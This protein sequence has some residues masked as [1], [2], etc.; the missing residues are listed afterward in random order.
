MTLEYHIIWVVQ[1]LDMIL[2][3]LIP[4]LKWLAVVV[5]TAL[6]M[7]VDHWDVKRIR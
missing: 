7:L 3:A 4:W 2:V 1:M 6:V 5:F